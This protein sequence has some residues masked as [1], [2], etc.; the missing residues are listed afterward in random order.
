MF[1]V[2]NT[3]PNGA[4]SGVS[5]FPMMRLLNFEYWASAEVC[6]QVSALLVLDSCYSLDYAFASTLSNCNA[7]NAYTIESI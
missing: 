1:R 7:S 5:I 2:F 6:A 3:T 4:W